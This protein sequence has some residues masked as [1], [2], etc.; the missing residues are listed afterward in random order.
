MLS[1]LS[2]LTPALYLPSSKSKE[3]GSSSFPLPLLLLFKR[4]QTGPC[5]QSDHF[6]ILAVLL[7]TLEDQTKLSR[8]AHLTQ[9]LYL[10]SRADT[11]P[12]TPIPGI[13]Q[14][15]LSNPGQIRMPHIVVSLEREKKQP[16]MKLVLSAV[17]LPNVWPAPQW[18]P[19]HR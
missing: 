14:V 5:L 10:K 19:S 8:K 3:P 15:S 1:P 4:K 18:P 6:K 12:R 17:L 11:V 9:G 16:K 7:K 13:R 2:L